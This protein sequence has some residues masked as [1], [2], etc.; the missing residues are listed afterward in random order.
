MARPIRGLGFITRDDVNKTLFSKFLNKDI[1]QSGTPFE[2]A[3]KNE[4]F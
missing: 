4:S 3:K 1:N 2:R